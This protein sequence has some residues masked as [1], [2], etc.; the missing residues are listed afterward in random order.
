MD[1]CHCVWDTQHG[2]GKSVQSGADLNS[3]GLNQYC[4]RSPRSYRGNQTPLLN[5][6]CTVSW[7][8]PLTFR[9][10]GQSTTC[11]LCRQRRRERRREIERI[12]DGGRRTIL[13]LSFSLSL[14]S[15]FPHHRSLSS[16]GEPRSRDLGTGEPGSVPGFRKYFKISVC[17]G[18]RW[19]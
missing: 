14:P 13:S 2:G 5:I 15:S 8:S 3:G 9:L 19:V 16:V 17:A 1:K 7:A 10:P 18:F 11:A 12:L 6:T 4:A